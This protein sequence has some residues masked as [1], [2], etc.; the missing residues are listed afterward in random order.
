MDEGFN[1]LSVL[2]QYPLVHWAGD[3]LQRIPRA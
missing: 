1:P 2:Y 3:R